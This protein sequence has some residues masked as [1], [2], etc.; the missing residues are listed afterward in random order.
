MAAKVVVNPADTIVATIITTKT[1]LN[2][3]PM[4]S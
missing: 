2:N 4:N 3:D 1:M